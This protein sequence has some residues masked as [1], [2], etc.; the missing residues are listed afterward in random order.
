MQFKYSM[1]RFR[2]TNQN[3]QTGSHRAAARAS[4]GSVLMPVRGRFGT[5]LVDRLQAADRV[6]VNAKEDGVDQLRTRFE[7][8]FGE[9]WL[10]P[11]RAALQ[12]LARARTFGAKL[13]FG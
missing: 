1:R 6:D 9:R 4:L 5:I 3:Q 11:A 10:P 8:A 13:R 2:K 7:F 12:Q